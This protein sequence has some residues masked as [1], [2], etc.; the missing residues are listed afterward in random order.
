M[1]LLL[2]VLMPLV[3]AW[4]IT[5]IMNQGEFDDRYYLA[6]LAGAL[7]FPYAASAVGQQLLDSPVPAG[8]FYDL[9][10]RCAGA[11]LGCLVWDALKALKA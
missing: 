4:F 8:M 2:S 5:M 6:A 11:F 10:P 9:K 7:L 1:W 3:A